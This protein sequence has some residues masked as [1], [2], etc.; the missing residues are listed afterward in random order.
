[1]YK[2]NIASVEYEKILNRL[3]VFK[4]Q[5]K[6]TFEDLEK[7]FDY[8]KSNL[9][10]IFGKSRIVAL[11]KLKCFLA[12]TE[13]YERTYREAAEQ[14]LI[15]DYLRIRF[16]EMSA[17]DVLNKIL[18]LP[19]THSEDILC[20]RYGFDH[21]FKFGGREVITIAY[22]GDRDT[23]NCILQLSGDGCRWFEN[24]KHFKNGDDWK[25]FLLNCYGRGCKFLR[26]D[27][28][29]NDMQGILNISS[30]IKDIE[31]YKYTSKFKSFKPMSEQKNGITAHTLYCG[32]YRS[33]LSFCIYEKGKELYFKGKLNN[34]NDSAIINRFEIRYKHEK[35]DCLV[36]QFLSGFDFVELFYGTINIYL[37]LPYNCS[38]KRFLVRSDI[39]VSFKI[40]PKPWDINSSLNQ[41]IKQYGVLQK[42]INTYN[43]RLIEDKLKDLK[44]NE[45]ILRLLQQND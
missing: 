43:S 29:F 22:N 40:E 21:V 9:I 28:A 17:N 18:E 1:M 26:F 38:F 8:K 31:A 25:R 42:T 39:K 4:Q 41:M 11:D 19:D 10:A 35:A 3:K 36:E 7:L 37:D 34:P 24:L 45:K 6:L 12:E 16:D 27:L 14:N 5:Y 13:Y 15:I 33:Q 23:P 2:K 20:F 32:S 44:V 30:M